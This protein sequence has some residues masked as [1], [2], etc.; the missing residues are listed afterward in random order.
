M[1]RWPRHV[2]T[3]I[4]TYAAIF[5]LFPLCAG[6]AYAWVQGWLRW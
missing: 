4:F 3:S 6:L 5:I 2:W 1:A